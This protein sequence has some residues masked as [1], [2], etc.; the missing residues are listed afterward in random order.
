MLTSSLATR[1]DTTRHPRNTVSAPGARNTELIS[2]EI[3]Y[4]LDN[5]VQFH[6][7]RPGTT[8]DLSPCAPVL[9]ATGAVTGAVVAVF[10]C[11][12]ACLQPESA[13][14]QLPTSHGRARR[15]N[16]RQAAEAG[17]YT[18]LE[19]VHDFQADQLCIAS[20]WS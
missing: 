12:S 5:H 4:M 2:L 6:N 10:F 13:S 15:Q 19:N 20:P 11:F 1:G 9:R 18:I 7:F 14:H 17:L 8:F 3:V 16:E